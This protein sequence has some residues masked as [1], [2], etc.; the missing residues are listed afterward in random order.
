[1]LDLGVSA[2]L[3]TVELFQVKKPLKSES[4]FKIAPS[5][6]EGRTLI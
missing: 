4:A 6:R 2:L 5:G 1:M 3:L